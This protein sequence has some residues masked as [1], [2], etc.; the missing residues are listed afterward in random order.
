MEDEWVKE[1][2]TVVND[3]ESM[4]PVTVLGPLKQ[5]DTKASRF[6]DSS[7]NPPG[8]PLSAELIRAQRR[9]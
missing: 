7:Q 6:R 3:N 5:N 4:H 8:S 9:G 2:K 1:V